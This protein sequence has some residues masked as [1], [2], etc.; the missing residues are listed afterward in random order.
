MDT[1]PVAAWMAAAG[2]DRAVTVAEIEERVA[3]LR[4]GPYAA[5]LPHPD[6]AEGRNLRRWVVQVVTSEMVIA[7]EAARLGVTLTPPDESPGEVTLRTA[8]GVGGVTA[9]LLAGLPVARALHRHLTAEI[10]VP[11]D[12]VRA[13]YDRNSDRHPGPYPEESARIAAELTAAE[14]DRHFARWLERR[15]AALVRLEPGFE[16]PGDPHHPDAT[17]HH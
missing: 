14:R 4:R 7:E 1:A 2:G 8:L 9:T 12:E 15:H 3:A 13:Y 10:I 6:T 17:H 16:H 11:D 5:R